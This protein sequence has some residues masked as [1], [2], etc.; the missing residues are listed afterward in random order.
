MIPPRKHA[1]SEDAG[2]DSWLMS[3]ADM[4]T[5]LMCFFIIFVSVSEPK[6]ERISAITSGLGGKFGTVDISTPFDGVIRSLQEVV[7][8]NKA[9]RDM[10]IDHSDKTIE[11][12]LSS[13]VFFK[14][15]SAELAEDKLPILR[16]TIKTLKTVN[17]LEYNIAIEAH[18][19]D[20]PPKSGLFATNWELSSARAARMV[21]AFI[22]GGIKPKDLKVI[23]LADTKPKVPNL[24]ANGNAITANREKNERIVIKLDRVD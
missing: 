4:I 11:I 18:T 16:D 1:M 21:R 8:M 14:P 24:D 13:V 2:I 15:D 12:E 3:Y 23:G 9:F 6:K 17:F 19:S 5:L 22:E 10:T 7:E 20:L